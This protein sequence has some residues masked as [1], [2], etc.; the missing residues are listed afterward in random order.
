MARPARAI[1]QALRRVRSRQTFASSERIFDVAR[2]AR[3]GY[4]K[5]RMKLLF[6]RGIFIL[7]PI[8]SALV[9]TACSNTKSR[10]HGAEESV[11][12]T[13][14]SLPVVTASPSSVEGKDAP[15]CGHEV[16]VHGRGYD[17]KARACLWDAYQAGKAASVAL[18]RHTIEGDPITLTLRVH[19]G[20]SIELVENNQDRFGPRGVRTSTC[21]T[22]EQR[23]ADDGRR[24]FIL[25]GCR[26]SVETFEIP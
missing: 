22:L 4:L 23:V 20:S 10:T 1:R 26:G 7:P 2:T 8:M 3:T 9:F 15:T 13:S 16:Q 5:R 21:S 25:R 14:S 6:A 12:S 24:G 17:E 11:S 19:S 18:T